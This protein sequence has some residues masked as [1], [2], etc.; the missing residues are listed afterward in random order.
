MEGLPVTIVSED[1]DILATV[2]GIIRHDMSMAV[3]VAVTDEDEEILF[4]CELRYAV[5]IAEALHRGEEPRCAVAP[6][7][8]LG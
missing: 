7:M 6:W 4:A 8:V 3:L 2:T 1:E 5:D